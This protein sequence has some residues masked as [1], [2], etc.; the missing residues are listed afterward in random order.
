MNDVH[1]VEVHFPSAFKEEHVD[2]IVILDLKIVVMRIFH[3]HRDLDMTWKLTVVLDVDMFPCRHVK[4][5][6]HE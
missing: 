2:V 4:A 6:N 1:I 5:S 3:K